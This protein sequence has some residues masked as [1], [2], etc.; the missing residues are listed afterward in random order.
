[1]RA[2]CVVAVLC[3]GAVLAAQSAPPVWPNDWTS[4]EEDFALMYQGSYSVIDGDNYCC[5]DDN[6]EVQTQWQSGHNYFDFTNQRTRFD[7]PV[8]GSIVT[9]FKPKYM[10]MAVDA[11]NTCTSY[12]PVQDDL[13]PYSVNVNSTDMGSKVVD[14]RTTEDWQWKD[15]EF[16]V[17][18]FETDDIYVDQTVNPPVPVYEED[19]LTPFGEAI[20][21]ETSN[22]LSFIYGTPDPSHFAIKGVDTCPQDSQCGQSFRQFARRRNGAKKTWLAAYTAQRAER[23]ARMAAKAPRQ[24]RKVITD[25]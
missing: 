2:A 19:Q 7:D 11:N 20:G 21:Y 16:G 3:A 23:A 9:L 14:N 25:L 24:G 5:S 17:L 4:I 13:E 22:Y 8:Q 15:I 12:C 6:C 1:M 18:V 10:E